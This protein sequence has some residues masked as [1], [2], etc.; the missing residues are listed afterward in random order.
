[1][2]RIR[3][4][5][6]VAAAVALYLVPTPLLAGAPTLGWSDLH[7]GGANLIDDGFVALTDQEGNAIV[8]GIHTALGGFNDIFVRKLGRADGQPLWSYSYSAPVDSDMAVVDLVI[9][10]RGDILVAGYLSSCDS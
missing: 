6:A 1:M 3:L 7:D 4:V 9:D 5:T 10:H 8:A 2:R